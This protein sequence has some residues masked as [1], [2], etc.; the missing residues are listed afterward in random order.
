[1]PVLEDESRLDVTGDRSGR[2]VRVRRTEGVGGQPGLTIDAGSTGNHLDP[3][4][5]RHLHRHEIVVVAGR[6]ELRETW[7]VREVCTHE[8]V[9]FVRD[10]HGELVAAH[11]GDEEAA[12]KDVD[13][14]DGVVREL[15]TMVLDP[16]SGPV[17]DDTA[18][19]VLASAYPLLRH[20]MAQGARPARIPL[21]V[22]PLL[23]HPDPRAA[24]RAVLGPRVTRPLI[25]ALAH[26]LLPD[27]EGRIAW[28]P[29]V[30][31][32]MAAERCGPEQLAD[33][34][35][36]APAR[37]GAVSFSLADVDRARAFFVDGAP[38]RVRDRLCAALR[39]AGGTAAFAEE[40]VEHDPRPPAPPV[41]IRPPEPD[42]APPAPV[43]AAAVPDPEPETRRIGYPPAWRRAEGATVADLRV[44]LPRTGNDLLHWGTA[45]D[46]C[47]GM[48]RTVAAHG[49][50]RIM[51]FADGARLEVVAEISRGRALRQLEAPGNTRPHPATD[52]A[53]VS[54]LR[55]HGLI[56][57]DARRR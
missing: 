16:K 20:P 14:L 57:T 29:I 11:D 53:I 40:L 5:R 33:V 12:A 27:E 41:E 49:R 55:A 9:Q 50:T 35:R 45:M 17:P 15:F 2:W 32:V 56:E 31:A 7:P 6:L 47:L 54:F 48:Y 51:G 36:A 52:E 21:A 43:A 26:A 42:A 19:L 1:M 37:P 38:R 46:N 28:E 22:E 13:R 30:F 8:T 34:L 25:R 39:D 23:H 10:L 4:R 24:A 3:D 44:V 18:G